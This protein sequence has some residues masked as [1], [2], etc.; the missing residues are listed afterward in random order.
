M[1]SS[2]P[3]VY[4]LL[5]PHSAVLIAIIYNIDTGETVCV[6]LKKLHM[7]WHQLIKETLAH[8]HASVYVPTFFFKIAKM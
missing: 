8:L 5:Y 4:L 1:L 6:F 3:W 2:V 7:K